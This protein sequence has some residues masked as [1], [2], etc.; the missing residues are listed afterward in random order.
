MTVLFLAAALVGFGPN[1]LAI[2]AGTRAVRT[3]TPL[4]DAHAV[5]MFGWL[6]VMV[7]QTRLTAAGAA[8]C[9]NS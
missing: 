1:T 7:T 8:I 5:L 3:P 6:L 2:L 9:I 4:F